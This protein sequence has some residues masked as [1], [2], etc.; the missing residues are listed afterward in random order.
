[1]SNNA[2]SKITTAND[3]VS[4]KMDNP[5]V[6]LVYNI[7][8]GVDEKKVTA[9]MK[10]AW[11]SGFVHNPEDPKNPVDARLL[12]T[13]WA[14]YVRLSRGGQGERDLGRLALKWLAENHPKTFAMNLD[15]LVENGCRLDDLLHVGSPEAIRRFIAILRKDQHTVIS[16]LLT[17]C[18]RLAQV[19]PLVVS[20]DPV[21]GPLEEIEACYR[22]PTSMTPSKHLAIML[23]MNPK[24]ILSNKGLTAKFLRLALD[25][26]EVSRCEWAKRPISL[27]AKW[28][29]TE[30]VG[31]KAEGKKTYE[32]QRLVAIL[33]KW[34]KLTPRQ[35]R[36]LYLSPLRRYLD[37][38]ER[39]MCAK[40]WERI[41]PAKIP[42]LALTRNRKALMLHIPDKMESHIQNIKSGKVE[43]KA[44]QVWPHELVWNVMNGN[45]DE[46]IQEQWKALVEK[47]SP[48]MKDAMAVVDVSGSMACSIGKNSKINYLHVAIAMGLM[49][50]A[51]EKRS[52]AKNRQAI[53]E[54][55]ATDA[56]QIVGTNLPAVWNIMQRLGIDPMTD[57]AVFSPFNNMVLPFHSTAEL[58]KITGET[59]QDQVNC[60]KS[61]PWGMST[62]FQGAIDLILTTAIENNLH[63]WDLPKMLF[64]FSDM[65][66]NQAGENYYTNHEVLKQKFAQAGYEL[67]VI[68][69]WN[70]NGS[71][72]DCPIQNDEEHG[73]ILLSGF[74]LDILKAIMEGDIRS[75]T[76]LKA[77]LK[78]LLDPL[79]SDIK[80]ADE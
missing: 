32:N 29:P 58:C 16:H 44:S 57:E 11:E 21:Y 56:G 63:P 51:C 53:D 3:A 15:W 42:S 7:C 60:I 69:Y 5:I 6:Q 31:K 80:V 24:Q 20:D 19:K 73:V 78:I 4:C 30:K 39:N 75:L 54:F 66:F 17:T 52:V 38:L 2:N 41:D 28:A 10:K 48:F 14:H 70:L 67:P 79:Y 8:R 1:M 50:S 61:I 13:I 9:L 26:L 76:P 33:L 23:R 62:N 74:S 43:I 65:Q 27:A 68:V 71:N 45:Y 37:I 47:Y 25:E 36:T 64:V 18:N 40:T 77:V 46:I 59:L 49:T 35:Y 22:T 12:V 55:L 72:N 34:M